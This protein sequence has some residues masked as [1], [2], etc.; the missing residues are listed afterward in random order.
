LSYGVTGNQDGIANYSYQ[1]VYGYSINS[2]L[3]EFGNTYYNMLTPAAYDQNIKWEQTATTNAGLDYGFFN[4]RLSGSIDIYDKKT[5]NLLNTI[6]IPAGTNFANTLLANVGNIE[7]KGVE[8]SINAT[9]IRTRNFTW[10]IA[11]NIAYNSNKITNLTAT[12]DP[13]FVG[14]QTGTTVGGQFVQI[15]S[16][17]YSTNTFFVYH[18]VYGKDGKPAEGVYQDV[19]G[20]GVI[21]QS[22]LYHDHSGLP[23]EILGFSTQF[24]YKRWSINTVLRANIGNYMYNA[25]AANEGVQSNVLNS[26]GFI[27]NSN[28]DLYKTGFATYQYQS[29]Y[30]IQNASFLKMD[31]IGI[32]YN[33]GKV[34]SEKSNLKLSL[35]CQNVFTVTKYTGINPEI[36]GGVDNILYPIPRIITLGA[37]L[38]F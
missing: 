20:D 17:G 25:V 11:F 24:I 3:Y 7:N 10:D 33:V 13:T 19:N 27:N 21:N 6:P 30:Y 18:Q 35:N 36:Y 31:N 4:N 2:D 34:F 32:G 26:N 14:D 38:V 28:T 1:P 12:Q 5:S 9:P 29:D 15:N 8:F 37:N 23:A 16:V 22:D